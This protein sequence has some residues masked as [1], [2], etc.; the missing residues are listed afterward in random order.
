MAKK[1]EAVYQAGARNYNWVK[2]KAAMKSDLA[3]TI[4][5]VVMGYYKGRGKRA[6]FGIG[7]FL[8]G[9]RKGE[10]F[11]TIS[12]IGTGLSDEQWQ[13]M[14]PAIITLPG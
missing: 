7:A 12:K 6:G 3:D 8:V 10:R 9:I 14:R 1:I 4:D 13:E 5:C 11:L 2:Y